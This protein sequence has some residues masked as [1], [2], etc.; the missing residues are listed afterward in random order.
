MRTCSGALALVLASGGVKMFMA[1]LFAVML[2]DGVTSF[3]WTSFDQDLVWG[4]NTYKSQSPWLERTAWN[5]ANTMSVPELSITLNALNDGFNGGADIKAQIVNGLFD[6]ATLQLNR[7]F[8]PTP[9]DTGSLGAVLLFGGEFSDIDV[10]GISAKIKVKGLTNKLDINVPR[11]VYQAGCLHTFC[12]AGCTLLRADYTA[13]YAVGASPTRYFIPWATAPGTPALYN[14]GTI[15]FTSGVCSGQRRTIQEA[16]VTG[17]TLSYPLYQTPL[18]GDAFTAFVGCDKQ[19]STCESRS[20][21]QHFRAF[22]VVPPVT[23]AY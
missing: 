10:D 5:V 20:N 6:G 17:I 14:G 18:T 15:T 2:A 9:G 1:D 13:S 3:Y 11:N 12:D 7:V 23:A 21:F 19:K 16:D 4:G 22:P 8:M